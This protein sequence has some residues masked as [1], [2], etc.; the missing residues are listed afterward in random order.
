MSVSFNAFSR[1]DLQANLDLA[2]K[3][4]DNLQSAE[5]GLRQAINSGD[6]GAVL[7]ATEIHNKA[8]EMYS[9]LMNLLKSSHESIMEVIRNI[10]R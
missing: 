8:K 3:V 4:G 1:S 10:G 9:A 7:Q 2:G 6:Q 5:E